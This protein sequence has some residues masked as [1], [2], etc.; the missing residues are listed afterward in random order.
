MFIVF[1]LFVV[2]V[3]EL[4]GVN[5][6]EEVYDEAVEAVEVEVEGEVRDEVVEEALYDEVEVEEEV[7]DEVEVDD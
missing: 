5:G 3:E 4:W 7:C 2:L 6:E 1:V